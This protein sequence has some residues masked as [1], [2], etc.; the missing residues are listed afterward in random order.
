MSTFAPSPLAARFSRNRFALALL[1]CAGIIY[2]VAYFQRV[3]VP[4]QLFNALQ[5]SYGLQAVQVTFLGGIYLYIYA[6][7]QPFTGLMNDRM[8]A[9]RVLLLGGLLLALGS[10]LFPLAPSYAL[11][12]AARALVGLGSS[13]IFISLAKVLTTHFS[14]RH[15]PRLLSLVMFAGTAGGVF[16]TLPVKWLANHFGWQRV[17]LGVG[18]L[19]AVAFVGY[20]AV[21]LRQRPAPVTPEPLWPALRDALGNRAAWPLLIAAPLIFGV[22]FLLQTIIGVKFLQD[23]I[24]IPETQ[25]SFY[26]FVM[27]LVTMCIVLSGG[28]LVELFGRRRKPFMYIGVGSIVAGALM[29]YAGL[30]WQL[31][32]GW[33]LASFIV[34]AVSAFASP[35]G[36]VLMRELTPARI[37]GT[38][39]GLIN[40]ASYLTVALLSTAAGWLMD[41]HVAG[42][43]HHG[44][45]IVY[46]RQAYLDIVV[47]CLAVAVVALVSTC[48]LRETYGQYVPNDVS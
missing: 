2:F 1:V 6:S 23:F 4:G 5:T 48:F 47:L 13:L 46:P 8:G 25:A 28:F 45:A 27:M 33:F 43:V 34:T 39:L 44:S 12:V 42:A 15:F 9:E 7:M 30:Q 31:G 14:T 38:A 37:F 26:S 16:G 17:L 29:L 40:G 35:V 32:S 10:L 41:R 3:A 36:N 18:M 24:G 20:A 22:Y 19:C 11:L 21:A